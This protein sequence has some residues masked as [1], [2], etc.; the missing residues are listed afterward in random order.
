MSQD[1]DDND[2]DDDDD[3][4]SVSPLYSTDPVSLGD[5][6]IAP[7]MSGGDGGDI[8]VSADDTFEP[9][10]SVADDETADELSTW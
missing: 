1:E 2:H 5:E 4:S 6:S 9:S 8:D 3:D 7:G 10:S